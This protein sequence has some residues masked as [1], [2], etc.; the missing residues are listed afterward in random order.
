[1]YSQI[2]TPRLLCLFPAL[3]SICSLASTSLAD[4]LPPLFRVNFMSS[5]LRIWPN[6]LSQ[7]PLLLTS[8]DP[9]SELVDMVWVFALPLFLAVYPEN[10]S[11][12]RYLVAP[13]LDWPIPIPQPSSGGDVYLVGLFSS[14][15]WGSTSSLKVTLN[16]VDWEV[17]SR[18]RLALRYSCVSPDTAGSSHSV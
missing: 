11:V 17:W 14:L 12:S 7:R 15:E 18:L 10:V 3:I 8:C 13:P 2:P 16:C 5:S 4:S 1:M 6:P 9:S